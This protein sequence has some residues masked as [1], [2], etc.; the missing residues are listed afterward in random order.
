MKKLL[1]LLLLYAIPANATWSR[2]QRV[3]FNSTSGSATSISITS[4]GSGHLIVVEIGWYKAANCT[5]NMNAPTDNKGGGSSTYNNDAPANNTYGTGCSGIW[6]TPNCASGITQVTI[7]PASAGTYALGFI[8][9]WSGAATTTPFDK[10]A[11]SGGAVASWTTTATA[12]LTGSTDLAIAIMF[13]NSNNT[14][15]NTPTNSFGDGGTQTEGVS[16]GCSSYTENQVLAATTGI[17]GTGT[18]STTVAS[19]SSI[20]TYKAAAGTSPNMP[21]AVY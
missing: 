12:T 2:I 15:T 11:A 14:S 1:L 6:S 18:A 7:N 4:T 3:G 19:N 20:A 8:E 21:P 16:C 13:Q 10:T 5:T 17:A 9:E